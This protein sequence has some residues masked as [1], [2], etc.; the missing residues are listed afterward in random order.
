M[1]TVR[2]LYYLTAAATP[3]FFVWALVYISRLDQTTAAWVA[4]ATILY[5]LAWSALVVLLG[6]PLLIHAWLKRP[7][8]WPVAVAMATAASPWLFF[9]YRAA[10]M[11]LTD[12]P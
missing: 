12:Q 10:T 4:G 7:P 11:A 5:P 2:L 9:A 1:Q 8:R 3:C 6:I